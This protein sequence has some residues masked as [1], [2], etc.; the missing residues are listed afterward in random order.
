M[1]GILGRT[2]QLFPSRH[3]RYNVVFP[4]ESMSDATVET[5]IYRFILGR[6]TMPEA[7]A[8]EEGRAA[9]HDPFAQH[10]LFGDEVP[11]LTLR[12]LLAILDASGITEQRCFVV[13]DGG[14]ILWTQAT[15]D[16]ERNFRLAVVCQRP[17]DAQPDLL[18]SAST[19][20]DS[21]ENFLQVIGWDDAAGANQFYER[22]D[23][24]WMWAG[25]GWDA[26]R[27][28][29]RGRG[30]FDSHVNGALNMKELKLPWLH[31]HSSAAA[32]SDAVLAP[33]DPLRNEA[34]WVRRSLADEFERTVV[35]PGIDR[36]TDSRFTKMTQGHVLTDLGD[37]F[38][39]VLG[40]STVNLVSSPT[41]YAAMRGGAAVPLP[42]TFVVD[43][44]ALLDVVGL[45]P[46]LASPVVPADVYQAAL[47]RFDVRLKAK[48]HEFAQDTHFVFVVPEPA[49]EDVQVLRMLMATGILTDRLAAAMLMVDFQNPIFST[50]RMQLL[51]YVPP[52]SER[53]APEAFATTFIAAVEASPAAHTAGS[54][55]HDLL[56]NWR[57]DAWATEYEQRIEAFA[58][59]VSAL[60][61]TP[62]GF[63]RVFDLAESRR[64]EFRKRKLAEFRLT[65]PFTNVPESAPLLEFAPD[66]GIRPK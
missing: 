17:G 30:P 65:T 39:Q 31:W 61:A 34:V 9:L 37:F 18:I 47:S 44:D 5:G 22:R 42:P 40:T 15:D 11:P 25:S 29:T 59:T 41:S 33:A 58:T 26:L 35:R 55:E 45:G 43:V 19:D 21:S 54:A 16:L 27:P 51:Q 63:A 66:G 12:D 32:F 13:A 24:V 38:R 36:W 28:D 14:Q 4:A 2:R 52:E 57:V 64:R 1:A 46:A 60:C 6:D 20:I 23:G 3:Y 62:D 7:I 56:G 50:R 8:K 49:F 48:R 10:V 53:D